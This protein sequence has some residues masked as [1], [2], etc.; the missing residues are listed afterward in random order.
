MSSSFAHADE[1]STRRKCL[2]I[3]QAQLQPN[4]GVLPG[5]GEI[6]NALSGIQKSVLQEKIQG[7][8]PWRQFRH[9]AERQRR[10]K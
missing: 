7:L 4:L 9:E 10:P 1:I 5:G 6:T 3:L 2:L 8:Q